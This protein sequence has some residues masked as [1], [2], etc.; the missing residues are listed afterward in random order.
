MARSSPAKLSLCAKFFVLCSFFL[1]LAVIHIPS[2]RTKLLLKH[3]TNLH[4]P[5]SNHSPSSNLTTSHIPTNLTALQQNSDEFLCKIPKAGGVD[6]CSFVKTNC[7]EEIGDTLFPYLLW[8]YCGFNKAPWLFFLVIIIFLL[9]MFILVTSTSSEYFVPPLMFFSNTLGLSEN[10][11]GITFI[12]LGNGAPDIF[13][14]M[15]GAANDAFDISIGEGLGSGMFAVCVIVGLIV[16]IKPFTV[17]KALIL[18]DAPFYFV[19]ILCMIPICVTGKIQ[20]FMVILFP[21]LYALYLFVSWLSE[22]LPKKRSQKKADALGLPQS[23]SPVYGINDDDDSDPRQQESKPLISPIS[24]L[25]SSEEGRNSKSSVQPTEQDS[26]DEEEGPR[27][28]VQISF[29]SAK[30]FVTSCLKYSTESIVRWTNWKEHGII[31]KVVQ[32]VEFPF[33]ILR[34]ICFPLIDDTNWFRV[35]INSTL[36]PPILIYLL[37]MWDRSITIPSPKSHTTSLQFPLWSLIW[38]LAIFLVTP[39][40][41]F[42]NRPN[43]KKRTL[44]RLIFGIWQVVVATIWL[45]ALACELVQILETFGFLTHISKSLLAI[46]VLA[47]GAAFEDLVADITI[48]R[49]GFPV[50]AVSACYAGPLVNSFIGIS[51]SAIR[52]FIASSSTTL[53]PITFPVNSG[54]IITIIAIGA[55]LIFTV[56]AGLIRKQKFERWFGIVLFVLFGVATLFTILVEVGVFGKKKA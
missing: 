3:R 23:S 53:S 7:V 25:S 50:T 2:N 12:A 41:L 36:S 19:C 34:Q 10:M 16:L 38:L 55:S 43:L 17:P 56:A 1:V 22:Y 27:H 48:A 15:A 49:Q 28:Q 14:Q 33:T 46:T 37:G 11:A 30:S 8:R 47:W 35:V 5:T 44:V 18:K 13:S 6:V 31:G 20:F 21:L 54:F 40:A 45:N 52:S 29:A 39:L 24:K 42:L 32:V 26:E 9:L 51:I 4:R